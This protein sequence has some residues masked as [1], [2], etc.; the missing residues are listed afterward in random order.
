[1]VDKINIFVKAGDGGNGCVSFRRE[2]YVAK[3]GPDGGDGGRGGDIILARADDENT[4]IR[5]KYKRKFVAPRGEDGGTAKF[6]GANGEDLLLPVPAGTVVRD[7][8]SGL[9][10]ADMS[11]C[12]RFVLA[13]GGKGGFGN[14]RFATAT[15]QVPRFAKSGQRGEEREVTLELKLLADVGLIGMPNAGKSSLLARMSDARP[16]IAGYPFT[17]LEP[18][19]GVV[20]ISDE[21]AF[22]AA[23]IP[24]LIEGAAGGAGLGYD[25]L[26]HIER[27]RLL[28]HLFDAAGLEGRDPTDD[29]AAI[30][31]ELSAYSEDLSGKPQ[32]LVANK[33]D[34][35][36]AQT[37][38]AV[39]ER[40]RTF[41]AESGREIFF[42]SAA[43]GEGVPELTRALAQRLAQLPPARVFA[44]ELDLDA[45]RERAA[46]DMTLNIRREGKVFVVEGQWLEDLL[47]SVNFSDRESLLYFQRT[48]RHTGVNETL[49]RAGVRDG[50]TVRVG[51]V[52]FEYLQ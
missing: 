47:A 22:V 43:T 19:L 7:K 14:R 10:L 39:Q 38:A 25:F 6:H 44:R 51:G 16:K 3:G 32:I 2:K 26:R 27:C 24:G 11:S 18:G 20:R 36:D 37:A 29:I 31:R 28:L 50:D 52:E 33:I 5:Y 1:M 17:T 35:L 30:D 4:L 42:L 49:E 34:L 40:L 45:E 8:E 9:V 48:L 41:A 12:E 46:R 13:R 21:D 23:D 15:R